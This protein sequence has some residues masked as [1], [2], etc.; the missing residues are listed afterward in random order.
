MRDATWHPQQ[1]VALGLVVAMV[2]SSCTNAPGAGQGGVAPASAPAPAP[3][4][5]PPDV[6]AIAAVRDASQRILA[7]T[8]KS[9]FDVDSKA[10]QLGADVNALF[11][12]VR[13]N[14]RHEICAGVLRGARGTLISH[15]AN[16]WDKAVLLAA[17]LRHHGR[18]VRFARGRLTP[19]RAALLVTKM[20][21][22]ARQPVT[23]GAV[24]VPASVA[25]RGRD[26][27]TRVET[28]WR[29]AQAD[30][31]G[32]LDR[33]GVVLGQT[34]PVPDAML[35][36]EAADHAWVGYRDGDRWIPLD[37]SAAGQPGETATTAAETFPQIPDALCHRVTFRAIVERRQ[38]QKLEERDVFI[39]PATAAALHGTSALFAHQIGRRRWDAGVRRRC[40]WSTSEPM[41]RSRSPTPVGSRRRSRLMLRS[42]R[43]AARFRGLGGSTSFGGATAPAG[44]GARCPQSR[45]EDSR[46]FTRSSA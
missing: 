20:F 37:P 29:A 24:D 46:F 12:F 25:A 44:A 22:Q 26:L 7:S 38:S 4:P 21:D 18:E 17:P 43:R 39:W 14:I 15:A 42:E 11:A 36:E 35:S 45:G 1:I 10:A 30:L 33:G 28:R 40:S 6:A 31:V 41:R 19:D 8:P 3:A 27:A 34:M 2:T 32:A 16:A 13:D 5:A 9:A 23:V